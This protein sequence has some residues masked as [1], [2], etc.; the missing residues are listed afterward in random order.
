MTA[1]P[2]VAANAEP[3]SGGIGLDVGRR[4]RNRGEGDGGAAITPVRRT[5]VERRRSSSQAGPSRLLEHPVLRLGGP[6]R[7]HL[8]LQGPVVLR[9]LEPVPGAHLPFESV[10]VAP[11]D[12]VVQELN[13]VCTVKDEVVSVS[14]ARVCVEADSSAS[15]VPRV[16]GID[17]DLG[18]YDEV[19]GVRLVSNHSLLGIGGGGAGLAENAVV[20]LPCPAHEGPGGVGVFELNVSWKRTGRARGTAQELTILEPLELKLKPETPTTA[21]AWTR[22]IQTEN[23]VPARRRGRPHGCILH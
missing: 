14:V 10:G 1:D 22:R 18:R 2:V 19:A 8:A 23:G 4:H 15:H 9:E 12:M 17:L 21:M 5:S 7:P 20:D 13:L 11:G 16:P 3:A 6:R